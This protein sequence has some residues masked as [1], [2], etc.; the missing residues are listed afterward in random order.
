MTPLG[1]PGEAWAPLSPQ[2][3]DLWLAYQ[4]WPRLRGTHNIPFITRAHGQLDPACL[5]RALVSLVS[6]HPILR[7]R[8]AVH[9]G[10]PMQQVQAEIVAPIQWHDAR[11][12]DPHHLNSI[13]NADFVQPFDLACGWLVRASVYQTDDEE[14]ILLIVFDHLAC[15]DWSFWRL[16]D[17]L[18]SS[19][20]AGGRCVAPPPPDYL[21]YVREQ[22]RW[23]RGPRAARQ[24]EYWRRELNDGLGAIDLALAP[25]TGREPEPAAASVILGGDLVAQLGML[26]KR[27]RTTIYTVLLASYLTLLHRMSGQEQVAVTSPLAARGGGEW[28]DT[29]GLFANLVTLGASFPRGASVSDLLQSLR[30]TVQRAMVHQDYPVSELVSRLRPGHSAS[31]NSPFRALFT[32]QVPRG[33]RHML[34]LID[35]DPQESFAWGGLRLSPYPLN[36]ARGASQFDLSLEVAVLASG[37]G[38]VF[39]FDAARLGF[40]I[41]EALLARWQVLLLAMVRD[42]SHPVG[43]L[44]LLAQADHRQLLDWNDTARE[45]PA[46]GCIHA[47]FEDQVERTPDAVA[48]VF[49]DESLSYA[50]LDARANRL[51]HHLQS[52]GVGPDARVALLLERGVSM[53]VALLATLKAGGAYVPLDPAYPTERLAFMLQDCAPE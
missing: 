39:R 27:H 35:A 24:L 31:G 10:Q 23:L 8:I 30:G 48:L 43:Q 29:A 45:F 14:A 16:V 12:F 42:D 21:A 44:P 25:A 6:R 50:E 28:D 38:A 52:L 53:V 2:Q 37:L 26:A 40:G 51:A 9:D 34:G 3:R 46:D 49:E 7:T 33:G 11:G 22:E 15:D 13:I 17:E 20:S 36:A 47:L 41:G 18:G 1:C 5:R 4:R 19:I 32:M